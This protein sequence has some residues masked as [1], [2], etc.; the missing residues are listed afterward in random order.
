[1]KVLLLCHKSFVPENKVRSVAYADN[2][3]WRTEYYVR[4]A[5]K[6]LAYQVK[7][8]AID[9]SLEPLRN[10]IKKFKP[11]IVFNMVEEFA[12]EGLLE[13][14]IVSYLESIGQAFTGCKS[15]GLILAKNKLAA[16]IILKEAKILSPGNKK[17]PKIVKLV[18]EESSRGISDESIVKNK[19][20]EKKQ[21]IKLK[22]EFN[23]AIFSEEYIRGRELHVAVLTQ[24]GKYWASPIW[25]TTF[26]KKSG[27]K[28]ISEKVKWNFS[29]RIKMGIQLEPAKKI[30]LGLIKKIQNTAI[31][32]CRALEVMGYARVDIRLTN[33]N[34]VYVLEVNPNPD[35]SYGDEFAECVRSGGTEYDKLIEK[36]VSEAKFK[37]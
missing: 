19:A 34:E 28:I 24:K 35:I 27:A 3:I 7:I 1:M 11:D 8:C 4:E 31:N 2:S 33:K 16:K 17:Y 29:Y 30:E 25:E 32:A 15:I 21:I 20:E 13:S 12:G 10:E 22:N 26:G 14:Y 5:L 18:D 9:D 36:I 6:R 23:S 37:V